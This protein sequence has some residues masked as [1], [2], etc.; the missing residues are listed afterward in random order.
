MQCVLF[1]LCSVECAVLCRQC[2]VF[3]VVN[4][5]I[6]KL[7]MTVYDDIVNKDIIIC[8]L[9]KYSEITRFIKIIG[10]LYF[11]DIFLVP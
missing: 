6:Y 11:G 5:L 7:F 10:A 3:C 9:S 4:T 2:E 8:F 1:A